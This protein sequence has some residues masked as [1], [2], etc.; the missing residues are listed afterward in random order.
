[1]RKLEKSVEEKAADLAVVKLLIFL[2]NFWRPA[3]IIRVGVGACVHI[4]VL[5]NCKNNPSIWKGIYNERRI[6]ECVLLFLLL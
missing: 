3:S 2:S 1:M 5:G 6:Y 4:F